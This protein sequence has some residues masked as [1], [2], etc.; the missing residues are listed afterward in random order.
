MAPAAQ[1]HITGI[2]RDNAAGLLGVA[3]KYSLCDDDA[4]DACQRTLEIYLERVERVDPRTVPGWLRTVCKHEA[5]RIR[6]ARERQ[7]PTE[8]A[9]WDAQPSVEARDVA[10]FAESL[11]RVHRAAE[12]LRA[13]RPEEAR[14]ILMRAAGASYADI[15]AQCGWTYAQVNR[16]V[17][18]GRAR[19]LSRFA[20]IESGEACEEH[21]ATL[22][23]IVDGEATP[24]DF[25]RVRPHLR[26]CARCRATLRALY[27]AEPTLGMPAPAGALVLAP[28]GL[29]RVADWLSAHLGERMVRA[30]ALFEAATT[31]KAA[32]VLAS[33]A[34]V[35]AGGAAVETVASAP[36]R[37]HPRVVAVRHPRAR[38]V[39]VTP[40]PRPVRT[41]AP[42]ATG[43][44]PAPVRTPAPRP[45]PR[46]VAT[47]AATAVAPSAPSAPP[48]GPAAFERADAPSRAAPAARTAEFG[49]G[50]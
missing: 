3:R 11:E 45:T 23:A 39:A 30:H 47:A 36:A 2:V 40:T 25:L 17:A 13:C 44:P 27:A 49:F 41:P 24:E 22:S 46:P 16:A 14:A 37:P 32:A 28:T 6:A 8:P 4:S 21:A 33:T 1:D 31:S 43:V 5:M 29:A 26:H 35:A 15:S 34:A 20:R 7:L 18:V 19:F 42:A 38:V 48:P 50:G 12:A 10:E 9:E